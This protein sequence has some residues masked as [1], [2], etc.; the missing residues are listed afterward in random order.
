MVSFSSDLPF[1]ASQSAKERALFVQKEGGASWARV[2]V[3][4]VTLVAD[5]KA[6]IVKKLPSLASVDT[7]TLSLHRFDFKSQTI[8]EV[9][10][11]DAITI[12]EALPSEHDRVVVCG[13]FPTL[14]RSPHCG[15]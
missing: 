1:I 6:A 11:D 13:H 9:A 14:A 2:V 3:P 12:V 7:S 8:G 4:S 5:L 10:L 15:A